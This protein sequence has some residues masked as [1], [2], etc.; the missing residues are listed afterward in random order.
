[1]V[2]SS[3]FFL[4]VF[5]PLL[6]I[7][8]FLSKIEYRN[9]ILLFASL[10]FYSWGEPK[11]CLVMLMLILINYYAAI[12]INRTSYVSRKKIILFLAI[13]INIGVLFIYK[14]LDFAL[15]NI[16]ILCN[17]LSIPEIPLPGIALPIGISFYCFQAMSY[18]ID[19][20]RKEVDVQKS[21]FNL[22]LYIS[23]FPQL[24]AGPI[25]RY[26]TICSEL[27]DRSL[28]VNNV[29]E[30]L[31]RFSIGLA[32]KVFIADNMGFI[33]DHIFITEV[34]TI[35]QFWAWMGCIAYSLQIY[36]DFSAY[37]DMAIGL[38]RIFNFHF[39]ENFNFPYCSLSIKEFWRRWHISLSSWL[40][41]YLYIPLGGNRIS[42]GRTLINQFIVFLVCG[43]WRGAAWNFILWGVW[44]GFGLISERF[45]GKFISRLPKLFANAYVL[46]FVMIG[47]VLFR[48]PDLSYALE[49]LKIM[50]FGN[51]SYNMYSFIPAWEYCITISNVLFMCLGI[52]FSYPIKIFS[53][54]YLQ[55]K[56]LGIFILMLLFIG[57]YVFS[58]TSSFS[59]FI[60]FRF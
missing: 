9:I 13:F 28:N 16:N 11:A 21:L 3:P 24:V 10:I 48:A 60:Y 38:G 5:L 43:L 52:V 29:Y 8:Y 41:D 51:S 14:Y 59:P 6:L 47:W 12:F 50:F 23:L 39:L 35:P 31:V 56:L 1:M 27:N 49:Y 4:S 40:R 36:Y 33:A 25:V 42:A 7:V 57:S 55:N 54:S 37:S 34:G 19:V 58:M 53:F 32:K 22:A 17:L 2:F 46:L 44:H 30:G 45:T 26:S 20:Y 15:S 18:T